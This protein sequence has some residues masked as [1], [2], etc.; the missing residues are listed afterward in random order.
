MPNNNER[1]HLGTGWSFP[2]RTTV[3]GSLQVSSALRNVEESIWII[4][5]TKLGERVL[6]PDFGSR[7]S[8]LTFAPMNSQTLLLAR[9]YVEEALDRWEPRIILDGVYAD[10][11]P[12][13]GR[14]DIRI[15]Y[16]LVEAY[17]SRIVV[18]PSYLLP[19]S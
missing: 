11:D 19:A 8:E 16:R 2:L 9:L 5:G 6:R 3:Q 4:L 15:E 7:L 10:P 14:I 12:I 17:D 13:R 1:S 18:Y